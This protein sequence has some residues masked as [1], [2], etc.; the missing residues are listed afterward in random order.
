MIENEFLLPKNYFTV[1]FLESK[2]V[3]MSFY[4]RKTYIN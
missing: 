1:V 2:L 4:G 3:Y